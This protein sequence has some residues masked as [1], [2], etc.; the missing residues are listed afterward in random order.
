MLIPHPEYREQIPF[1]LYAILSK[2]IIQ[3]EPSPSQNV[4][5]QITQALKRLGDWAMMGITE[6]FHIFHRFQSAKT[7]FEKRH[8]AFPSLLPFDQ[9][10]SNCNQY[11]SRIK[12]L[13]Y[14]N[15]YLEVCY[16]KKKFCR[17]GVITFL[18]VVSNFYDQ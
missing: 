17:T 18:F 14:T 11:G 9:D 16:P 13:P 2:P 5:F 15:F 10:L 4:V 1:G 12:L 8:P 6:I 3:S 7:T